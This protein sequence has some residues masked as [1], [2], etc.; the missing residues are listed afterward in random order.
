MDVLCYERS[1]WLGGL[2]KYDDNA[3][4]ATVT[5]TTIINSSKEMSSFSDFPA[6]SD[7]PNYFHHS[8][9]VNTTRLICLIF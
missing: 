4:V 5:R 2:W 6:P 3:N 9:M 1:S 7:F 8:L